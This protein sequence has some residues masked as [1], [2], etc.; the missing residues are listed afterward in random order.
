MGFPGETDQDAAEVEAFVGDS[1][2]D[3]IGVFTY[4]PEE[5]TRSL[6]MNGHVDPALARER[7]ERVQGLADLAMERRAGSLIGTRVRVLVDRYD[8][9]DRSWVGRSQ[10]EAP[11]VDGEIA[12]SA[13]GRL[14]VGDYVNVRI[15]SSEGAD[16]IGVHES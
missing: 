15:T 4:S 8:L 6:G 9:E 10:R 1:D 16:L 13:D 14:H 2:I 7:T 5:G 3:W 11:E 12:F